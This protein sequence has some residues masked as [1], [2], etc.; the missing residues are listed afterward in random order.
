M[1]IVSITE[2]PILEIPFLN[3]GK[4]PGAFYTDRLPVHTGEVSGLPGDLEALLATADLQGRERFQEANC[5]PQR[6]LG[7]ALP[8][9][10]CS[11][12]LPELN[13]DPNRTGVILAGDFYTVPNLDKRG[14]SGDV[15]PVWRAFAESFR[16]VAGVAGNHDTFGNRDEPTRNVSG[17]AHYLDGN[18]TNLDS[19]VVAGIGGIIGYPNK[20][21]RKTESDFLT[22][23]ELLLDQ[24]PDVLVMHDGPDFPAN[25][26]RGSSNI[27]GTLER[28]PKTLVVRGHSHWPI[29]LVEMANGT[30]VLNVDCR[31]VI[32]R[33]AQ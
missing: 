12:L 22:Y 17:N 19:L 9:R 4:G 2:H 21:H 31:V 29:P 5:G 13:L 16:W 28:F 32:L 30:Q 10:L 11:E 14:G 20:L 3:A 15:L 25:D 24:L 26:L 8:E 7:E 18:S 27:R 1:R 33:R 23:T 6:L